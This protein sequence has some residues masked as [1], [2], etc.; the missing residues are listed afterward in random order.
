MASCLRYDLTV[1][2]QAT[3]KESVILVHDNNSHYKGFP[4]IVKSKCKCA[5]LNR[6]IRFKLRANKKRWFLVS[7]RFI[8]SRILTLLVHPTY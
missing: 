3:E 8:S 4:L 1:I 2:W 7:A 5:M 6:F